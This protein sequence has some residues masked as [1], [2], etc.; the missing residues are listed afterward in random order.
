[1]KLCS[2][3]R[4]YPQANCAVSACSISYIRPLTFGISRMV[5]ISVNR[6][7]LS[8]RSFQSPNHV[9]EAGDNGR[10][11]TMKYHPRQR[12]GSWIGTSTFE[13]GT[14]HVAKS[15]DFGGTVGHKHRRPLEWLS[16]HALLLIYIPRH[17]FIQGT[18][19]FRFLAS[20]DFTSWASMLNSEFLVLKHA[21]VIVNCS[22]NKSGSYIFGSQ[23]LR[24]I[25]LVVLRLALVLIFWCK[26]CAC[27]ASTRTTTNDRPRYGAGS[28][29]LKIFNSCYRMTLV[30]KTSTMN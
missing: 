13:I 30:T 7:T 17:L 14:D 9:P 22:P 8:L 16:R 24:S 1:M 25:R 2:H 10:M 19:Y 11:S 21:N 12:R 29:A 15:L 18:Y 5:T 26:C 23:S 4:T 3:M 20:P 6:L 27:A 28:P